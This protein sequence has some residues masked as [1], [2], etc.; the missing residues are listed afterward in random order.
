VH[1]QILDL[2]QRLRHRELPSIEPDPRVEERVEDVDDEVREDDER[3]RDQV[4][5]A[6]VLRSCPPTAWTVSWPMP[7]RLKIDSVMIAPPSSAARSRPNTVTIGVRPARRPCLRT[8][9]FSVRPFAR[10]VR[11]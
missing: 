3:R 6:I 2:E 9:R 7:G 10:A 1:A 5:T 11:M 4:I 8:T